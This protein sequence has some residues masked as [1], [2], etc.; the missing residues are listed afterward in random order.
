MGRLFYVIK[1]YLFS[2]VLFFIGLIVIYQILTNINE[3][4]TY[5]SSYIDQ[6]YDNIA[7]LSR[8]SAKNKSKVSQV[9]YNEVIDETTEHLMYQADNGDE[10]VKNDVR[11]Q[12]LETYHS[13]YVNILPTGMR[14]F[15]FHLSNTESLIRFH[16]PSNYGDLLKD[17]RVTVNDVI[18]THEPV[19]GIEEGRVLNGYRYV[20]PI[21][22]QS[23]YVGSVEFSYSL[24][25]II[26]PVLETYNLNAIYLINKSEV[27]KKIRVNITDSYF[28]DVRFPNS[29]IDKDFPLNFVEDQLEI[30]QNDFQT[31]SSKVRDHIE[32]N[33][34]GK[35]AF[36]YI[37]D[38]HHLVWAYPVEIKD[39]AGKSIGVLIYFKK[40]IVLDKMMKHRDHQLTL[41]YILLGVIFALLFASIYIHRRTEK[42]AVKDALTKLYNRHYCQKG[43]SD[44]VKYGILMMI[45]IDDFKL[46]NDEFGHDAG[47][48]VL[49][50]LA[51]VLSEN[52]RKS[53]KA[54]RWGGEEFL[55]ILNEMSMDVALE[56]AEE[57]RLLIKKTD[58]SGHQI[59]VSIGVSLLKDDFEQSVNQADAAM[60]DAKCDGKDGVCIYK[61]STQA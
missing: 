2:I 32:A 12:L 35:D 28:L 15:Q 11:S 43:L 49:K 27:E 45:D 61:G 58:M 55:I 6:T 40:D 59:T 8:V 7:C 54:I 48:E 17:F 47:D 53:D 21:F 23:D 41:S 56:K 38:S 9:Y 5:I 4:N 26:N 22:Y 60:Y 33:E 18:R 20:Y 25:G 30:D 44:Y 14:Q 1:K 31:L 3:Q 10:T 52:I 42:I 36:S 39:Y 51:Q 29:Y 57:I 13:F 16:N 50:S 37:R 19:E 46:I 24:K 34:Y